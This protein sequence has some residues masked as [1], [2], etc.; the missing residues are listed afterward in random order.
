MYIN[1]HTPLRKIYP[2]NYMILSHNPSELL[3]PPGYCLRSFGFVEREEILSLL[4]GGVTCLCYSSDN[5]AFVI[6]VLEDLFWGNMSS[7]SYN[8]S[9]QSTL[10]FLNPHDKVISISEDLPAV[11]FEVVES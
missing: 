9:R 10:G 4:K 11:L 3:C 5:I 7:I 2:K 1:R 8:I 6:A